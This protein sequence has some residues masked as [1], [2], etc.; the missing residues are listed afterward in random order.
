MTPLRRRALVV[1]L[2]GALALIAVYALLFPSP[3]AQP[4]EPDEAPSIDSSPEGVAE[5]S[6]AAPV[7]AGPR[8]TATAA[9]PPLPRVELPRPVTLQ[10]RDGGLRSLSQLAQA[11]L[12]DRRE[13]PGPNAGREMEMLRFAFDTLEEDVRA[14]LE[15]WSSLQPGEAAEVMISFEI[16]TDGLQRSWLEH[17]AGIPFGPQTCFANAV[18][19]LDWSKIVERPAM[20]TMPFRLDREDAGT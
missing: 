8:T 18:Y 2:A 1:V 15:E 4:H 20:L 19:G 5:T 9:G 3:G 7:G 10:Q 6:A 17:D 14:C 13:H 11:A 16:D 12:V